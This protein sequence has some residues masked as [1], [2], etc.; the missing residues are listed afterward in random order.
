LPRISRIQIKYH[1]LKHS[2][3]LSIC[4][5]L[6]TLTNKTHKF[7]LFPRVIV[8]VLQLNSSWEFSQK[9]PLYGRGGGGAIG[10][11]PLSGTGLVHVHVCINPEGIYTC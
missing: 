4:S 8:K 1:L 9:F 6:G 2:L 5:L 3:S 7:F 11:P 10:W